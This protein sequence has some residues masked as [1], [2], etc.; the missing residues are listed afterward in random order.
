MAFGSDGNGA[1]GIEGRVGKDGDACGIGELHHFSFRVISDDHDGAGDG[2]AGVV[3]VDEDFEIA[4]E[5]STGQTAFESVRAIF[6][7]V[8][9]EDDEGLSVAG[10]D[11]NGF[12]AGG[13]FWNGAGKARG[14]IDGE[15]GAGF[16]SDF[17]HGGRIEVG[18]LSND[19]DDGAAGDWAARGAGENDV[20][21]IATGQYASG[22]D[23]VAFLY[24][25]S[26]GACI[27][28]RSRDLQPRGIDGDHRRCIGF[29]QA[30][31]YSG[32]RC[33]TIAADDD[34]LSSGEW[35]V[36]WICSDEG[37]GVDG[38]YVGCGIDLERA[39]VEIDETVVIFVGFSSYAVGCTGDARA[40]DENEGCAERG[41]K[42]H[43]P[44]RLRVSHAASVRA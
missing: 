21:R 13:S 17:R 41:Y 4:G 5:R 35:S 22:G 23:V 10:G 32:F 39:S 33:E 2:V 26:H 43:E 8:S 20:V 42:S 1:G 25:Q 9:I 44:K 31:P 24:V 36:S 27:A 14:R 11:G 12:G 30:K 40:E 3:V 37:V 7:G 15:R 19:F 38:T 6:V 34:A 28:R 16:A 29:G 18:S